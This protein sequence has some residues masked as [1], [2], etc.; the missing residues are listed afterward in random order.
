MRK[1]AAELRKLKPDS[2]TGPDEISARLLKG[3]SRTIAVP[4]ALLLRAMLAQGHWPRGWRVHWLFPLHKKKTKANPANYRGIHLTAQLSK[5]AERALGCLFL[6]FLEHVGAY[7]PNQFAY[8]RDRGLHDAL[9][10][11]ALRWIRALSAGRRVGLYCSDVSGAFD[12]VPSEKLLEKLSRRGVHPQLLAI[13]RSWLEPRSAHVIVD[14]VRS[15][16]RRLANSV[17]QGTVWGPPLWNTY[18]ADAACPVNSLGFLETIFADDLN[19]YKEFGPMVSDRIILEAL[20]ECQVV[21]HKWGSSQQILFDS[22]KESFHI[23]ARADSYGDPFKL[24]GVT[25]DTKLTMCNACMELSAQGHLRTRTILRLRPYY[26][27]GQ[28][29]SFY[30]NQVLSYIEVYT[31]AIHHANDFFL[32]SVDRVQS[33]FLEELGL[34]EEAALLEFH[35]APLGA[36]RDIAILGLLHKIALGK[37]PTSLRNLL[38]LGPAR[39]PRN[40]RAPSARHA[41]QLQDPIDGGQSAAVSRSAFGKVDV[42]NLLPKVVA[43]QPRV[44][45]FQNRLQAGL[46]KACR[47]GVPAWHRFLSEG[48]RRLSADSFQLM[49]SL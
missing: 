34:S 42:Y 8:T 9:A 11:N 10:L 21:L 5:V 6:P 22:G 41:N 43:E 38:P 19:A 31:A 25:F 20:Q 3:C 18:F 27:T 23:L 29:V 13:I 44:K 17:Y 46:K 47:A 32:N 30:R 40:L 15:R 14:G 45:L 37:A 28:L 1:V 7:G 49:L 24:L 26:C 48:P 33:M 2:S 16:P 35:F 4:V 12:R 36:R 39:F